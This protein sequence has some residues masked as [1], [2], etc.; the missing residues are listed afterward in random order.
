MEKNI[1]YRE[2]YKGEEGDVCQLV[3]DCFNEYVAPGYSEEGIVEFSKYVT[4]AF[5]TY[6]LANNHFILLALDIGIIVG[7]IEARNNNH[8]SLFF[9]RTEYQNLG[10]GKKLNELAI[11]KCKTVRSDITNIEVHSSPYAVPIYG[12]LGFVKVNTEQ[13]VNGMRFTPMTFNIN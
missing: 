8:I 3:M 10:I 9:V 1:T 13:I 4:P 12:K 7:V 5:T 2:I 11:N 6:R